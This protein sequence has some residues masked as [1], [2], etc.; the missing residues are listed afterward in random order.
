[1]SAASAAAR[2]QVLADGISVAMYTTAFGIIAAV[3]VLFMHTVL[4]SRA[5][6]VLTQMEEG[7]TALLAALGSRLREAP[8]SSSNR[9]V[10]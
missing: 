8:R 5:D 3:P 7:A 9:D 2:Q 1:M 4:S 6:R 10:A